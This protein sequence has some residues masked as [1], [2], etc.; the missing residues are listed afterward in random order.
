MFL[1][2]S[3]NWEGHRNMR[4]PKIVTHDGAD[5]APAGH[6]SGIAHG[7]MVSYVANCAFTEYDTQIPHF[8]DNVK[9]VKIQPGPEAEM[10]IGN[11]CE[12][13]IFRRDFLDIYYNFRAKWKDD[14]D[15]NVLS[16]SEWALDLLND[17]TYQLEHKIGMDYS[18]QFDSKTRMN[19]GW[20]WIFAGRNVP[21]DFE[22]RFVMGVEF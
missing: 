12:K 2:A 11:I 22:A 3:W 16:S 13:I 5:P 4:V 19:I 1:Q 14:I 9:S 6:V 7:S 20:N 21:A 15:G 17:N 8:A 10:R 18:Y